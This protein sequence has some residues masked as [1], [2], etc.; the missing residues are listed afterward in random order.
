MERL[1]LTFFLA[2]NKHQFSQF[3]H[4]TAMI[5]LGCGLAIVLEYFWHLFL[6]NVTSLPAGDTLHP[7]LQVII[8]TLLFYK[9]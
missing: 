7:F 2:L 1:N 3:N 6:Y 5:I 8:I 9:Y 4:P